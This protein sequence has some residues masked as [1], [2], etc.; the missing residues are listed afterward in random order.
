MIVGVFGR[1]KDNIILFAAKKEGF[2]L[3]KEKKDIHLSCPVCKKIN[4]KKKG[5]TY[6]T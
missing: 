1:M 2:Q 3:I 4:K 5:K 6:I